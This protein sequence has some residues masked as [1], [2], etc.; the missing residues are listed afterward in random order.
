[1]KNNININTITLFLLLF[2]AI[3]IMHQQRVT[4]KLIAG[5]SHDVS[6][7]FD[8]ISWQAQ[9]PLQTESAK[10]PAPAGNTNQ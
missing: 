5:L 3:S 4:N 1:M 9:H 7:S 8:S 2:A 10:K 6:T